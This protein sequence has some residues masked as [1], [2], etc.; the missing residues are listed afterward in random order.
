VLDPFDLLGVQ[1]EIEDFQVGFH[2]GRVGGAGQGNHAE[3]ESEAKNDLALGSA[4]A[5]GDVNQFGAEQQ[6]AVG[7]EQGKALVGQ[8]V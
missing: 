2:V 3:V 4:V 5:L 1:V 8:S 7:G 6:L